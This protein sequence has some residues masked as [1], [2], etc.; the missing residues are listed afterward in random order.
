MKHTGTSTATITN[1]SSQAL[2]GPLQLVLSGLAAGVTAANA[3]GTWGGNPY[4]TAT[5]SSL[6]PGA[7]VSVSVTLSYQT[8]TNVSATATVVSGT[9]RN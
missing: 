4:W 5:A 2:A 3:T 9:L 1:I 8:G 7:S 6:A